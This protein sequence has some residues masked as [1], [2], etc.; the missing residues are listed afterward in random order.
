VIFTFLKSLNRR[1]YRNLLA[2][3]FLICIATARGP[4]VLTGQFII[5]GGRHESWAELNFVVRAVLVLLAAFVGASAI[6]LLCRAAPTIWRGAKVRRLQAATRRRVVT[7]WRGGRRTAAATR[8]RVARTSLFVAIML[9]VGIGLGLVVVAYKGFGK[10]V[11]TKVGEP[12][13]PIEVTKLALTLVAGIGGAVAL[14]VAYRRQRDLEQGRFV[15]RFGAAAAQLGDSDV[16]VRIAGVYAMAGVADESP[17]FGRRQQ[18]IDVLSGY[19]RLP[20]RRSGWAS[21]DGKSGEGSLMPPQAAVICHLSSVVFSP[22]GKRNASG[23][24]NT[25]QLWLT[26]TPRRRYAPSSPPI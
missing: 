11:G 3:L 18:C 5:S 23:S 7:I 20:Y 24:A 22:D 13:A 6:V 8:R 1:V 15:E 16:A 19:L 10:V 25:V 14:V 21:A 17:N 26:P 2:V 12:A 9:A 4:G